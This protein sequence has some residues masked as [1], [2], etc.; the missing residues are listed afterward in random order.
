MLNRI[1]VK[2]LQM[3]GL[4]SLKVIWASQM[5]VISFSVYFCYL[6]TNRPVW[7]TTKNCAV[8]PPRPAPAAR[9]QQQSGRAKTASLVQEANRTHDNCWCVMMK[10]KKTIPYHFVMIKSQNNFTC[11]ASYFRV[12][13]IM[14]ITQYIP[15]KNDS[16]IVDLNNTIKSKTINIFIFLAPFLVRY[17]IYF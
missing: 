11:K 5:T 10:R 9:L 7:T 16:L 14:T 6:Y 3:Y 15:K 13:G 12:F 1:H 17:A 2:L 4:M 8:V